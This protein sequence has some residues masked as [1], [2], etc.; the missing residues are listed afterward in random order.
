MIRLEQNIWA[1]AQWMSRFTPQTEE[2]MLIKVCDV[3]FQ[4]F[5]KWLDELFGKTD[6]EN[7]RLFAFRRCC[8]QL[9]SQVL[10]DQEF[11]II[12][13]TLALYPFSSCL[14]LH[15]TNYKVPVTLRNAPLWS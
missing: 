11:L 15:P 13:K 5:D 6:M 4:E 10:N 12:I 9:N 2:N 3:T 7:S 14:T 1:P 8:G